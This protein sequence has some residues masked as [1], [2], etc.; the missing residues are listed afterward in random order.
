MKEENRQR[1]FAERPSRQQITI[2]K[3]E[4]E[5]MVWAMPTTE[6]AKRLG[7][8]DVAIGKKCKQLGIEKPPRG[9]WQKKNKKSKVY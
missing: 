8:S 7:V 5:K 6:V 2:D 1:K 9:Y 4:L 3:D